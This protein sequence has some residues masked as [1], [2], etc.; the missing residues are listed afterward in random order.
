MTLMKNLFFDWTRIT[1]V[2]QNVTRTGKTRSVN[3]S[4]VVCLFFYTSCKSKEINNKNELTSAPIMVETQPNKGMI[5][6]INP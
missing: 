4:L 1:Q 3:K 6:E 5:T 2:P